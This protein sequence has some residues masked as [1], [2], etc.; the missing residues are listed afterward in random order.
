MRVSLIGMSN[1]GKTYWA[2]HLA[3]SLS[4][5]PINCDDL[6]EKKLAPELAL[7]GFK[8]LKGMA[9]WMGFPADSQYKKNSDTYL[10]FEKVVMRDILARLRQEPEQ[11]AIVDTTGSIIYTGDDILTEL[12]QSTR[13]VYI[14]ATN[15]HIKTLFKN[16]ITHPKPVIWGD[17]YVPVTG[18]TEKQTLRR[19]YPELLHERMRRYKKLAHVCVP[20]EQLMEPHADIGALIG[21]LAVPS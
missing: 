21:E 16:Y 11:T 20:L 9:Q 13:V 2:K 7:G 14:E 12:R 15:A 3:S 8:G 10:E 6:I 19:C 18:E 4:I 1:I 17:C 5:E